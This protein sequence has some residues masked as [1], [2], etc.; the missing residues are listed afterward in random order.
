[1]KQLSSHLAALTVVQLRELHDD[2]IN[3]GIAFALGGGHKAI[4]ARKRAKTA[5]GLKKIYKAL[6]KSSRAE[7]D[8]MLTALVWTPNQEESL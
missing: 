2:L 5:G 4:F 6:E 1:M 3:A 7:T 8:A